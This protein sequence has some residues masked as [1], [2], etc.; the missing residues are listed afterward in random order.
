MPLIFICD[1]RGNHGNH[2]NNPHLN[3]GQMDMASSHKR[4]DTDRRKDTA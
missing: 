1:D 2:G 4:K 3:L